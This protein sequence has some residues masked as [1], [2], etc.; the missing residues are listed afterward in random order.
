MIQTS[1]GQQANMKCLS[2]YFGN[3]QKFLDFACKGYYIQAFLL[4]RNFIS[5][6]LLV[7]P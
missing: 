1:V 5:F 2:W 3:W 7:I 4:L 6:Y